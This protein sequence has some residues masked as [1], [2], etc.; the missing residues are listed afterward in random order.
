VSS[1]ATLFDATARVRTRITTGSGRTQLQLMGAQLAAGVGNLVVSMIAARI[2]APGA[3]AEVV[4][5]LALYLVVN[6]PS[7][8]LTAAGAVDP[9]RAGAVRGRVLPIAV[10][11]GVT[12]ALLSGPIG[13]AAGLPPLMIMILAAALPG[14]AALGL[15]RGEAYAR[16]DVRAVASSLVVEPVARAGLGLVLMLQ[17]GASGA[18]LAAVVGG[19]AAWWICARAVRSTEVARGCA[20][21][22]TGA[23]SPAVGGRVAVGVGLSFIVLAVLQI[24]DLVFANAR[25]DDTAAGQF[26]SLSTIG[27]GA[28]FATA[29]IPLVLLP[30]S[31]RGDVAARRFA[32]RIAVI[33]GTALTVVGGLFA[34]PIL[35][36][37]VGDELAGAAPWLGPYLAAMAALGASRVLVA[38]R[39]TDGDGAFVRRALLSVLALQVALLVTLGSS[40]GAVVLCTLASAGTLAGIL[41]FAPSP[42]RV[43]TPVPGTPL[44]RLVGP[45]PGRRPVRRWLG[46][47]TDVWALMGLCALAAALRGATIRGL[48]VDEA[49]SVQQAQLPFSEMLADVRDRD[50]HP[51]LHHSALWLTVRI[52]GISES[53]VRLPS[54]V[55]GVALIPAMLWTGRVV[56]NRRTGWIAACFAALAP[57]SVWYSQEARMYSM[58]M[59]FATLAVGAQVRAIQRGHRVDWLLYAGTTA[60]LLWT[61]Y[62]AL[63]PIVVQQAAFAIVAV[64]RRRDRRALRPY[65]RGWASSSVLVAVAALPLLPIVADQLAAYG[66]RSAG[67]VPGQA[68]AGSSVIG[69]TISI[70][71]VGANLVWA[72]WGYHADGAMVQLTALWPLL[73][74]LVLVLLGR[75][76][77]WRTV[78]LTALVVV[79]MIALFAIGA[80]KRDLFE[81]RYFSGAVPILLLLGARLVTVVARARRV[82]V[83]ATLV[84]STTL[85]VGLL[86]QQLNGANPR[87]YDFEGA[88]SVVNEIDDGPDAVLLFEPDYLG[89]VIDYYAPDL[90]ARPLGSKVPDDASTV[91]VLV[92]EGVLSDEQISGRIGSVLAEIEQTRTEVSNFRRPNVRVWELR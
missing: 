67:T 22:E 12:V 23:V 34:E 73:M 54:L 26:G 29:T 58:F 7:A 35:R 86:D 89:D 50:V 16:H 61:Q 83:V 70:Y 47:R 71:A 10:A 39:W 3:Y 33:T 43:A 17:F 28:L 62:F 87:L 59:L 36:L 53:A 78:L 77:S 9:A 60:A 15:A 8:A 46:V 41:A 69:G 25:L 21:D 63:L 18:A 45:P 81:L 4:T 31:A 51:P 11:A 92:A 79:P 13:A 88:L 75:G 72:I 24:V 74:L 49:I 85:G 20:G 19:Y 90:D 82:L 6:V 5:F 1:P 48:W 14:A 55:A 91:W 66:T 64:R 30:D 38:T 65:L 40:V 32:L 52:F 56:Y 27:G 37:A 57:F 80:A 42:T 76:R 68:G 44:D 84:A 2:L